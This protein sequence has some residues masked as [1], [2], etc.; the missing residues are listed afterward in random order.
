MIGFC[1]VAVFA[2][3]LAW[4]QYTQSRRVYRVLWIVAVSV[5]FLVGLAL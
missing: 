3:A 5:V 1:A 2:L 4:A